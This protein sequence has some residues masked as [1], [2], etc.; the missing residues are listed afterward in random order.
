MTPAR[1]R[2]R[3]AAAPLALTLALAGAA[4]GQ[5]DPHVGYVYP[6]GVQ[7]GAERVVT[8]GGQQLAGVSSVHVSGEGVQAQ[9][10]KHR[11][12][13]RGEKLRLLRDKLAELRRAGAGRRGERLVDL[14]E[15][16]E[17]LAE[18]G[19]DEVD[20]E[21]MIADRKKRSDP[22]AQLNAQLSET[23]TV[24]VVVA[25]DAT[26]GRR[27][28]RLRAAG[29]L[30]N[31][32]PFFVGQLPELEEDDAGEGAAATQ[33]LPLVLNGQILPG[34]VDRFRFRA[35]AG[36]RL[37]AAVAA[38]DLVPY[39][40]DAVPGW[41]QATVTLRDAQGAVLSVADD[42]RFS[43]D[44]I[45]VVEVP[46]DGEYVLEIKDALFRGREDFVYRISAGELPCV[47]GVFPLGGPVGRATTVVAQGWNLTLGALSLRP[48]RPG[49]DPAALI[50]RGGDLLASPH[51]FVAG[52]LPEALE[53]EPDDATPQRL[54]LP[55]VVNGRIE[56]PGD[57]DTFT[58][59]G[60]A[61]Q[62]I[63][64]EV[65]AR[66]LLSP[67]DS[68]LQ[69]TGARG[70][71]LAANDDHDGGP[72]GLLTHQADSLLTLELP[73]DGEYCL[74]LGDAQGKGGPAYGY[75][76]RV[77]APRPDFELR[78]VPASL[79]GRAGETLPI[80]VH[81]LRRDGFSGE[82][83][84]ALAGAPPGF[85]LAGG[86]IP[87]GQDAVTATLTA[88]REPAGEPVALRLEGVGGPGELRREAVPAEDMMQAFAYRHLV[89]AEAWLF[90]NR[91]QGA[92]PPP[93]RLLEA[94]PVVLHP[95]RPRE[96]RFALPR[97]RLAP[98]VDLSVALAVP[99]PGLSVEGTSFDA[100]QAIVRLLVAADAPA[101][102]EG[103]LL[104]AV[105]RARREAGPEGGEGRRGAGSRVAVLPAIPFRIDLRSEP[106]ATDE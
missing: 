21:G 14:P 92:A 91:G 73:A 10:I 99:V 17:L 86:R 75:R 103:N 106:G 45:L 81:V 82:I 52:A 36:A 39:L 96:L 101:G 85:V 7:R 43:P 100:A 69:L 102:L 25:P 59:S 60:R 37:V 95:G 27:E 65:D 40:A 28:L 47:T 48:E 83:T 84:L 50:F 1:A 93:P 8:I 4:R 33:D 94:L 89:P 98:D 46:A 67:L 61:G 19:L 56:R 41:F 71:L 16:Q 44:P 76:L 105:H 31:P 32:L 53:R 3:R 42:F 90:A 66:R 78:V 58:F 54:T 88:P 2:V 12:P 9:V 18:L 24:R 34:E 72:T 35:R 23:V 77:S 62:R 64:A 15:L 26:P 55:V 74:R 22:L 70:A 11:A 49:T 13:V 6:A 57:L 68:T 97:R 80:R 51:P 79:N 38:R 20:V 5:Q 63:V 104:L 30:S 87:A 29:G